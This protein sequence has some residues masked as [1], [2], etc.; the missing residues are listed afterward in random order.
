LRYWFE[1]ENFKHQVANKQT[2]RV[3]TDLITTKID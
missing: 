2:F 3:E 1:V